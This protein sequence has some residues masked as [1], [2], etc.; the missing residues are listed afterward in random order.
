[1]K[2]LVGMPGDTIF[3][4]DGVVFSASRDTPTGTFAD[5]AAVTELGDGSPVWLSPQGCRIY[6]ERNSDIY[7]AEKPST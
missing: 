6:M 2:R 3:S 5:I 1:M 7:V 4:R